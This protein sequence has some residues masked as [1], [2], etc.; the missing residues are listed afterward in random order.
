[1]IFARPHKPLRKKIRTAR[2]KTE[3]LVKVDPQQ[4]G[5]SLEKIEVLNEGELRAVALLGESP[6]VFIAT[7][8][9]SGTHLL[10]KTL[11]LITGQ[12]LDF[13]SHKSP[14]REFFGK[15]ICEMSYWAHFFNP[16]WA[17][18]YLADERWRTIVLFRDPRDT[19]VSQIR[20]ILDADHTWGH[21]LNQ[22]GFEHF[23]SLSHDERIAFLIHAPW[24]ESLFVKEVLKY[25]ER[26]RVFSLRFEDLVGPLGGGDLTLQKNS[27]KELGAFIGYELNDAT[28]ETISSQLFGGTSTFREGKIG[29]WKSCFSEENKKLFKEYMGDALIKLGYETGCDW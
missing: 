4:E 21:S 5:E 22:E 8:P 3:D 6:N 27:V 13:F 12:T 2:V 7:I 24:G 23:V 14:S 9:K 26:P 18:A 16:H 29:S 25:R 17:D 15:H 1:V 11:G 28:V 10:F 20:W 19:I